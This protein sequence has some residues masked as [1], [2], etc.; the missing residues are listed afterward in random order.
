ML[1]ITYTQLLIVITAAWIFV[2]LIAGIKNRTFSLRRELK[3]LLV[4]VCIIV[5]ARFV[6][7]GFHLVDGKLDT[8]KIA[9]SLNTPDMVSMIPFYF[10]NDRYAGWQINVIGNIAMFIPVGI[11]WPFCFPKLNSVLKTVLAGGGFS[12]LI[13]LLQLLSHERHS[14]VDDL[15]LNT[16]GVLIGALIFFALRRKKHKQA[17]EA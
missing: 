10:L 9:P 16:I 8:L 5:I 4:Y 6:F 12:L 3:L 11:V 1:E 17:K 7:F 14:D 13:E 2:R 15:I